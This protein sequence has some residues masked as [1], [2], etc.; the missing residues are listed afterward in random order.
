MPNIPSAI[1]DFYGFDISQR[2]VDDMFV[3]WDYAWVPDDYLDSD[4]AA[5]RRYLEATQGWRAK[6]WL[7]VHVTGTLA[8]AER[9]IATIVKTEVPL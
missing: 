1:A 7:P 5:N 4:P 3:V 2:P 9:W 6:A 8:D